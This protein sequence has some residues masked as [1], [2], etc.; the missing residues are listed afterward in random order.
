MPPIYRDDLAA[1]QARV[2]ELED[3]L[4]G[5]G[6]APGAKARLETI[7]LE[8]DQARKMLDPRRIR[9]LRFGLA[10]V[11]TAIGLVVAI[12]A[13]TSG[14]LGGA[15]GAL[16]VSGVIA[17]L[18]GLLVPWA[19]AK[20]GGRQLAKVEQQ[21]DDASRLRKLEAEVDVLRGELVQLRSTVE[22]PR[23]RVVVAANATDAADEE[24][25]AVDEAHQAAHRRARSGN[26]D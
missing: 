10:G 13:L 4:R 17:A 19:A 16:L 1:S 12:A 20:Q 21:L 15:L 11:P 9:L 14:N 5:R 26:S 7:T 6:P 25:D 3:E 23:V 2:A 24:A 22:R 18:Y 8:R